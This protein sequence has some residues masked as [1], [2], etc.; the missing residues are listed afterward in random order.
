MSPQSKAKH[1]PRP[2]VDAPRKPS[3]AERLK[4]AVETERENMRSL[5][6]MREEE[7][8]KKQPLIKRKVIAGPLLR[9]HSVIEFTG[10][11]QTPETHNYIVH[12]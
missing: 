7:A 5:Q 1:V 4:E 8:S 3:F 9:Y 2:A 11:S 12:L 6:R 10:P